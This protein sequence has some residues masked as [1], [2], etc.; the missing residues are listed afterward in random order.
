MSLPQGSIAQ[1][2]SYL[3]STNYNLINPGRHRFQVSSSNPYV[4]PIDI[5]ID[6]KP[7]RIYTLYITGSMD[8]NSPGYKTGN[9]PQIIL[10][11]DGNTLYNKC[12][13]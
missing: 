1:S 12:L 5:N 3:Q 6:L 13:V 9:I 2:L 8:S 4:R 11:V 10:A 7:G